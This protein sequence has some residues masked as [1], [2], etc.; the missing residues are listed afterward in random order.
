MRLA[1]GLA[2]E[3]RR[4]GQAAAA[5]SGQLRLPLQARPPTEAPAPSW[6]H[7]PAPA[8]ARGQGP[9]SPSRGLVDEPPGALSPLAAPR[10]GRYR[11]GRLIHRLLQSLPGRPPAE[12]EQ[13]LADYLALPS[14]GLDG[15]ERQEIAAEVLAVLALPELAALFGPGSRAEVPLAGTVGDQ[16]VF[17]Q[18]D[19]LAVT[20]EAVLLIDYKTNREPPQS[21]AE[22]PPVYLRQMAAYCAL[23]QAIYPD[24]PVRAALLW[25]EG[26]RLMALD[27]TTLAPHWPGNRRA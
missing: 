17:G 5:T 22:V 19:R 14:L 6:L 10:A 4:F 24:R 1:P 13:A 8:E 15:A 12:R 2:G 25:T 23:L 20:D 16:V 9:L 21:R 7:R 18:V 3:G 26:P 11:R 27:D